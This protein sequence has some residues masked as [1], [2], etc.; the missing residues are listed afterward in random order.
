MSSGMED[1]PGKL[2]A[3]GT[4]GKSP[5]KG[6]IGGEWGVVDRQTSKHST[7]EGSPCEKEGMGE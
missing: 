3:R 7:T 5:E 6:V 4:C 1:S 2:C